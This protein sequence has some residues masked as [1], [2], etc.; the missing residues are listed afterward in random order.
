MSVVLAYRPPMVRAGRL[1]LIGVAGFGLSIICFALSRNFYLSLGLLALSGMF[2]NIS[3]VIRSATMQL[4]AP[5]EMRGRVASVNSIFI[6]ASNELGGFESGLTAALFSP[7]ISVVAGGIGT[8]LVV[9][10]VAR[11]WP[12][13]RELKTLDVPDENMLPQETRIPDRDPVVP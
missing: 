8:L 11:V 13:M 5:D 3:V 4:V 10:A 7:I 1:L 12:E 2:D 6:G 9:L